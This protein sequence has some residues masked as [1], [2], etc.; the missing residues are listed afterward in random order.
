MCHI[1]LITVSFEDVSDNN[2]SARCSSS[3]CVNT[4]PSSEVLFQKTTLNTGLTEFWW[5]RSLNP[6]VLLLLL[7]LGC[8]LVSTCA[9][10]KAMA[11]KGS[12]Y[13]T[14]N[15]Q[16]TWRHSHVSE[17]YIRSAELVI[18][19]SHWPHPARSL[20]GV[21]P[22]SLEQARELITCYLLLAIRWLSL[23]SLGCYGIRCD[24]RVFCSITMIFN[25]YC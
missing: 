15:T 2:T 1:N 16:R 25:N 6:C 11:K 8:A 20:A 14:K 22:R 21:T 23:T 18:L 4:N 13:G 7:T 3:S 10:T 24:R 5:N 9:I 12:T 19:L 17:K